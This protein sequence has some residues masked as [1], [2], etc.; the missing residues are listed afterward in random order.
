MAWIN[1]CT[2]YAETRSITMVDGHRHGGLFLPLKNLLVAAGWTVEGSGDG[3]SAYEFR[4]TTAG[5]GTGA[6]GAFDVWTSDSGAHTGSAGEVSNANVWCVLQSPS[7][8][9]I[10]LHGTSSTSAGYDAY[11]DIV[12]SHSD[13]YTATGISATVAPGATTDEQALIGARAFSTGTNLVNYTGTNY[14][15]MRANDETVNGELGFWWIATTSG[16]GVG[17]TYMAL[18]PLELTRPW[19]VAPYVFLADISPTMHVFQ[20]EG[21]DQGFEFWRNQSSDAQIIGGDFWRHNGQPDPVSGNI[22]AGDA[23]FIG[24]SL[25]ANEHIRGYAPFMLTKGSAADGTATRTYPDYTQQDANG[26]VWVFFSN[27]LLP[28]DETASPPDPPGQLTA[29]ERT[30]DFFRVRDAPSSASAGDTTAPVIANVSPADGA[31]IT[32]QSTCS[33]DVTD[34]TGLTTILVLAEFS[35]TG[36]YE[37]VHDGANFSQRYRASTK[38]SISG[39]FTFTVTREGGWP[40]SPTI[41]VQAVDTGGNEI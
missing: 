28:W 39:G 7:G 12:F 6:G 17:D 29:T 18:Q 24:R 1:A 35:D 14:I 10:L 8:L 19:E 31:A 22:Q 40:A 11:G 9:E 34:E 15:C 36:A 30:V 2:G 37:V 27:M 21:K 16:T 41:R 13:G 33:F 20:W 25:T 38:V 3:A 5:S 23:I 4:G 26:Q 32:R